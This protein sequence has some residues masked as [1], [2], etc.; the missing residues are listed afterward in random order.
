MKDV[1]VIDQAVPT[2]VQDMLENIAL[3]DKVNWF[4]Q[5]AATYSTESSPCHSCF[6][7]SCR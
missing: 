6:P 1:I 3:G 4:R 5:P 2:S 7:L